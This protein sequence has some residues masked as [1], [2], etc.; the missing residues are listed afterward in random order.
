[1]KKIFLILNEYYVKTRTTMLVVEEEEVLE[2][3]LNLNVE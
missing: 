3:S 1:V 2:V